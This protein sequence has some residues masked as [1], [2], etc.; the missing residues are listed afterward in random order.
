M[1]D[2]AQAL[3]FGGV[4]IIS[5]TTLNALEAY[6][7]EAV[8]SITSFYIDK[9]RDYRFEAYLPEEDYRWLDIGKPESLSKAQS[10]VSEL[11]PTSRQE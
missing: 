7:T 9:C 8:F 4:H 1:T 6:A 11:R 5:P 2:G 3:A 10:I